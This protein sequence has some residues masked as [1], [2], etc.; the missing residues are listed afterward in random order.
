MILGF[1][2][3]CRARRTYALRQALCDPHSL[4][5]YRSPVLLAKFQMAPTPS[6]LM[7]SRFK[8]KEPRYLCLSDA[9][10]S[11]SHKICTEVSSSVPHFLQV[12]S[13]LSPI[14]CRCVLRVL[15]PVSRPITAL[16][17]VSYIDTYCRKYTAKE[18][19]AVRS[20]HVSSP[21][22]KS[23]DQRCIWK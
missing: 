1:G 15:C 4:P 9:K 5:G 20:E 18:W 16:D 14:T 12:G 13:A 21:L 8:K 2:P 17:A 23:T 11:H 3:A 19:N 7:S 6:T 22:H 10:A